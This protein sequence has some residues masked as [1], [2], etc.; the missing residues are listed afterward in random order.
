[1]SW[2]RAPLRNSFL[3]NIFK[4]N[5]VMGLSTI[6]FDLQN[7]IALVKTQVYSENKKGSKNPSEIIILKKIKNDWKVIGSLNEMQRTAAIKTGYT[8]TNL[9]GYF[10]EYCRQ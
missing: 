3:G 4:K 7:K 1:M 6:V 9:F 10:S 8:N 5:R 2:K